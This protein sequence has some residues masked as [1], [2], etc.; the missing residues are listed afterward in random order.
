MANKTTK[1]SGPA[2]SKGRIPRTEKKNTANRAAKKARSGAYPT[3][4]QTRR[5]ASQGRIA[6]NRLLAKTIAVGN[7]EGNIVDGGAMRLS[8]DPVRYHLGATGAQRSGGQ[9][10]KSI[11]PGT[12]KAK[13][14]R[15]QR[16]GGTSQKMTPKKVT[17]VRNAKPKATLQNARPTVNATGT[18]S[19]KSK[20]TTRTSRKKK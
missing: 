12:T 20:R 9:K 19:N 11:T 15:N 17:S 2:K 16:A 1:K 5:A 10:E 14:A 13:T 7:Y 3:K 6:E 4:E 8:G 18:T